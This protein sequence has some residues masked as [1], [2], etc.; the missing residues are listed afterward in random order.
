MSALL[1]GIVDADRRPPV[2]RDFEGRR[3]RLLSCG[4]VAGVVGEVLPASAVDEAALREYAR[5]VEALMVEGPVL[6][7][8]WGSVASEADIALMLAERHNE[9]LRALE[10][11]RGAVEFS[12]RPAEGRVRAV[13]ASGSAPTT[14]AAGSGS[15]AAGAGTAY[16]QAR[17]AAE[18]TERELSE[19]VDAAAGSMVRARAWRPTRALA[20]LVESDRAA[21]FAARIRAR[22]LVLTGPWPP[23]SFSGGAR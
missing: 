17:F 23:W 14:A 4:S 21:E 8:R 18:R 20:L 6:P 15:G 16:L 22:G 11:V 7:A 3:L 5:V 12:V 13:A 1:Y 9:L 2:Q 10:R 19:I